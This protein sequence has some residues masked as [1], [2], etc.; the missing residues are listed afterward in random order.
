MR[1]GTRRVE[2]LN[3]TIARLYNNNSLINY[4][5]APKSIY[6]EFERIMKADGSSF[7]DYSPIN[8]TRREFPPPLSLNATP[9][10]IS[11]S[12]KYTDVFL[13][14]ST[15]RVYYTN[16]TVAIFNKGLFVSYEIPPKWLFGGCITE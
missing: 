4:D 9:M 11:C 10:M 15:S 14:N 16:N 13:S 3:G 8:N 2:Y 7:I 6:Y 12:I 1:D 5:V